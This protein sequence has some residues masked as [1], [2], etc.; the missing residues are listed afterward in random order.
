MSAPAP[1]EL[2][3][4]LPWLAPS[5]P[6][7]IA[8][9]RGDT[10]QTRHHLNC[11]PAFALFGAR[12]RGLRTPTFA[13]DATWTDPDWLLREA[14]RIL[15]GAPAGVLR[16]QEPVVRRIIASACQLGRLTETIV[17]QTRPGLVGYGR[18]AG[19]AAPLG[20]LAVAAVDPPAVAACLNHAEFRTDPDAVQTQLWGA[21]AAAVARRL[22]R[23][24]DLPPWLGTV[25][26]ALGLPAETA[27]D[28]GGQPEL[29]LAVQA[30]VG[31]AQR[32]G[33]GLRLTVSCDP[34][35]A[36]RDLDFPAHAVRGMEE[37]AACPEPYVPGSAIEHDPY[38]QPLLIDLLAVA[39]DRAR[40]GR[41]QGIESLEAEVDF[42]HQ[43][44]AARRD[45]EGDRL[46]RAKLAALAE[47]AAGASHE[48]N[49]PLA[50]I[51]GQAQLLHSREPE[52]DRQRAL[53]GIIQQ[54]QRI[55][56]M[57]TDLMQ[58]ARPAPPEKQAVD[59]ADLVR[60]V[61]AKLDD[62]AAG[63]QVRLERLDPTGGL[64]VLGD[65]RQL[66]SALTCLV[67]NA[68]E[69]APHGGWARVRIEAPADDTVH[70]LVEDNGP[71]LTPAQ[72]AH[73]FDPFY[74]GRDAGRGRG[75]GLPT[76]WRLAV[77]QG[78]DVQFIPRRNGPTQFA[79]IVP[80]ATSIV[81]PLPAAERLSA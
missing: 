65:P 27:A 66:R 13:C 30:A 42:L 47:F 17:S 25:A 12:Q 76:A 5:A 38:Q 80:R 9:A 70:F 58:F 53:Q 61:L 57:L 8:L 77:E 36:L 3:V 21:T 6:A 39:E 44:L 1:A 35:E 81:A 74:S 56:Q 28:L 50:I 67:R 71:G 46:R 33:P 2:A 41:G 78:G 14:G 52:P 10:A 23:R 48:I 63:R 24:W 34:D 7:L 75:L 16:V 40:Q 54:A 31:L 29:F 20:W 55:N 69:A 11:D 60:D 37:L 18:L 64:T 22:T 4:L 19:M 26:A 43:S 45:S 68:I 62:A 32:T 51:S 15:S 49:T 72:Q 79:L 59:A 73:I